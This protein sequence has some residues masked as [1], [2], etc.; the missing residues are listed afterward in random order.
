MIKL[1]N[2]M[3]KNFINKRLTIKESQVKEEFLKKWQ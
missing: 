1:S 2:I 3:K